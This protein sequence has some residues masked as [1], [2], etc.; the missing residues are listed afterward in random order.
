VSKEIRE[1]ILGDGTGH[2]IG[3]ILEDNRVLFARLEVARD[4][5]AE[6]AVLL[7]AAARRGIIRLDRILPFLTP[8]A[9]SVPP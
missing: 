3:D 7:M 5:E 8:D 2:Y 6:L 1:S 4:C 9:P